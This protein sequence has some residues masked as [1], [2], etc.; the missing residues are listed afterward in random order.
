MLWT[1]RP[2][3]GK[4][5][6]WSIQPTHLPKPGEVD[7]HLGWASPRAF[8]NLLY[9]SFIILVMSFEILSSDLASIMLRLLFYLETWK[10]ALRGLLMEIYSVTKV[11]N[12]L[13]YLYGLEGP[14]M[15]D[16]SEFE[17]SAYS[18]CCMPWPYS[19]T[20]ADPRPPGLCASDQ[21]SFS[22]QIGDTKL[23]YIISIECVCLVSGSQL[24][25]YGR[26]NASSWHSRCCKAEELIEFTV[27]LLKVATWHIILILSC[28]R[29]MSSNN[30]AGIVTFP[31]LSKTLVTNLPESGGL[32]DCFRKATAEPIRNL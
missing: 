11:L 19:T 1:Y 16:D 21:F 2:R 18:A 15:P 25:W 4:G 30:H 32:G 26:E 27:R 14:W 7:L 28:I 23:L 8:F 17:T 12:L 29:L 31:S 13:A 3:Q 6:Q 24:R 9:R 22:I 10:Q 5:R 20:K